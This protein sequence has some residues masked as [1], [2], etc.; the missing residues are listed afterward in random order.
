MGINVELQTT[1]G[2]SRAWVGDIHNR[3]SWLVGSLYN[4]VKERGGLLALLDPYGD[5]T[6]KSAQMPQFLEEWDWL[7]T[8]ASTEEEKEILAAIRRMALSCRDD[9]SLAL[10]FI[11]D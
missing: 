2:E 8:K 11:G 9:P 3:L 1:H 5:C 7:I 10:V 4:A 6:F